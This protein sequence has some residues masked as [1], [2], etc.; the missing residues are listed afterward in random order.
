LVF[1]VKR[2]KTVFRAFE[3]PTLRSFELS[4]FR[5]KREKLIYSEVP[6]FY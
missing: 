3:N 2:F 1:V 6:I 5:V 4:R